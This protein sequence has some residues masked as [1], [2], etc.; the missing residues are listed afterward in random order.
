M[1]YDTA[2][3]IGAKLGVEPKTVY[4]HR[5]TRSGAKALGI[6]TNRPF[7]EV[8]EFPR[9]LRSLRPR[10]LEDCL[11]IYKEA[12]GLLRRRIS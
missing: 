10:E 5:G 4:L 9:Q 7:I 1:V 2:L 8:H 12:K 6:E 3:R 11:C